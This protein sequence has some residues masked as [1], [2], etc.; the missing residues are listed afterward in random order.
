MHFGKKVYI[1]NGKTYHLKDDD[2]PVT[3]R[4]WKGKTP[5]KQVTEDQA[6]RMGK[7]LCKNCAKEYREDKRDIAAAPFKFLKKLF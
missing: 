2:C 3:S 7:V 1:T 4:I 5:A 6:K